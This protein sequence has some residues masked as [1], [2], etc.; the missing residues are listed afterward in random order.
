M[1]DRP[2]TLS[3]LAV[4]LAGYGVYAAAFVP[5]MIIGPAVPLLLIGFVLQAICGV[6]AAVG[7]WGRRR[8][9]AAMVVLLGLSIA[10]TWLV[11]GFV[12]GIVA[13]LQALLIA[14]LAIVLACLIAVYVGRA[15]DS[16]EP[17]R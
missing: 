16:S 9:A 5:A 8:W 7:V 12:L 17:V 10:G 1:R 13:Y 11:E 6:A 2:A 4:V 3:A 15:S 14:V